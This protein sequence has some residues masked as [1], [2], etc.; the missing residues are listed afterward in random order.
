[1]AP[2]QVKGLRQAL[3]MVMAMA[4]LQ[5]LQPA[6]VLQQ[7]VWLLLL[8][9]LVVLA[10][11]LL[12]GE[13]RPCWTARMW[14]SPPCRHAGIVTFV[15]QCAAVSEQTT[16][17]PAGTLPGGKTAQK[18]CSPPCR[19]AAVCGTHLSSSVRADGSITQRQDSTNMIISSCP[20]CRQLA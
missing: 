15:Q 3:V 18:W 5:V 13:W 12:L 16:A 11:W 6:Q 19:Q 2:E 10:G 9:L 1:M 8:P 17:V 14:C 20:P 4:M 7:Q